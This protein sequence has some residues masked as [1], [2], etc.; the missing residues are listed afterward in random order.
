[1]FGT[2]IASKQEIAVY[3]VQNEAMVLFVK[4]LKRGKFFWDTRY[5][6]RFLDETFL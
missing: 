6:E 2:T 4:L 1:M 3:V 5:I